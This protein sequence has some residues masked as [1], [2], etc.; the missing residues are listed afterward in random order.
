VRLYSKGHT[1]AAKM[2]PPKITYCY[3]VNF[4]IQPCI[5]PQQEA[6]LSGNFLPLQAEYCR[7]EGKS[8]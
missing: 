7:F 3:L 5:W 2:A 8:V 4:L 6:G 1:K